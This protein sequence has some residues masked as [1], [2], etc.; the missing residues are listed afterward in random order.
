MCNV[1]KNRDCIQTVI[2]DTR[3]FEVS[4]CSI[5]ISRVDCMLILNVF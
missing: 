3:Y 4:V 5:E 1:N 2:F